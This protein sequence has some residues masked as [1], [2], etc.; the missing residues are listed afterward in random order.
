VV[1]AGGECEAQAPTVAP[2]V[3]LAE[4]RDREAKRGVRPGSE[5][6]LGMLLEYL[7]SEP[8]TRLRYFLLPATTIRRLPVPRPAAEATNKK[9]P[10][11]FVAP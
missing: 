4:V 10:L 7:A 8:Q 2:R 9:L 11:I 6:S 5:M 3:K 1:C